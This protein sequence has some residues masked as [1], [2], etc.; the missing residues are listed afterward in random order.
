MTKIIHENSDFAS[1]TEED[2]QR[3]KEACDR[4]V[5]QTFFF[6]QKRAFRK[7]SL[8]RVAWRTR[9]PRMSRRIR[10]RRSQ[11][12]VRRATTDSGGDPDPEPRRSRYSYNGGAL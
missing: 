2:A 6:K 1:L 10:A 5:T 7:W 8:I 4:C 11:A 3:F 12:S 9:T